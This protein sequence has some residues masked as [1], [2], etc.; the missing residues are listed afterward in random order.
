MNTVIET[1]DLDFSFASGNKILS[2]LNLNVPKGSIYCF[3]GPNGAG[4]TTTI[5]LLLRLLEAKAGKILIFGQDLQVNRISILR[6]IGSLIEQPSLY[7]HLSGNEN[8]EVSC[9]SYQC[10]R[11]R[12]KEVLGIAGLYEARNKPVGAYSLGMKQR[13]GIAL[14]LLHSPELLILDEP[15]NGLDPQGIIETRELLI[16]LNREEG[17]TI[18]VSSHL[19]SEAERVATHIGIIH[20]GRV[21]FQG[22]HDALREMRA[23]QSFFEIEIDDPNGAILH[24]KDTYRVSKKD[25]STIR[26]AGLSKE[27]GAHVIES[28]VQQN[29]RVFNA[30]FSRHNLEDLFMNIIKL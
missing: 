2:N 27:A 12:I 4:K 17:K 18:F 13:L 14:T 23:D 28:L 29:I 1:N 5:R 24:L 20:Q 15:T 16:R 22:T 30:G 10:E 3:L 7:S 8:L 21:R 6:R 11:R 26:L 25:D 19:L 9:M